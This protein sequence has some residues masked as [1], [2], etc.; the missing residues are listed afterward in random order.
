[1]SAARTYLVL[2]LA[3]IGMDFLLPKVTGPY[4]AVSLSAVGMVLFGILQHRPR[5]WRAWSVICLSQLSMACGDVIY[6]NVTSGYPGPADGFYLAA[7][8]LFVIGVLMLSAAGPRNVGFL[9]IDA[10][11]ITTACG[12][13]AWVLVFDGVA[14]TGSWIGR[15]VS[16]AY[17]LSDLTLL[18]LVARMLLAGGRRGPSFWFLLSSVIAL[19]VGDVVWVEPALD[20]TYNGG[21][22][23]MDA[24]WLGSYA[25]L[26]AAAL[27][28][29]MVA[30][31]RPCEA[32]DES[33]SMTRVL[34]VGAAIVFAPIAVVIADVSGRHV[35]LQAI[36]SAAAVLVLLVVVR[37]VLI[38]RDLE[39]LRRK[40]VASE[41]KFRM[42]F[43]RSPIGIS[44]GRD[45]I[46]SETNPA[47]QRMLGYS[48][49]EFAERHF[50]EITHPD[51]RDLE[52]QRKF[53][54]REL[55]AISLD[56][57]YV[58]KDGRVVDTRVRLALAL[59]DGL[60]MSLIEDVTEH[61]RLEAELHDAQK[62]E[63]VGKLA[64]GVAHDFNN[65]MTAVLGY[66]DLILARLPE[67][68]PNRGKLESI[69]EASVR[70][71]DL[72]RQLLAFGRKQMLRAS[73][74]DLRAIVVGL[75]PQLRELAGGR[76][77][78]VL[79]GAE[80]P[81]VVRGDPAQLEQVV[82]NLAENACEAMPDGGAL[83][84]EIGGD[85]SAAIL[86][87]SDTGAGIEPEVIGRIFEPFFTT[88]AVGA[89]P[90]LGLSTVYGIV[91]QSGGS[92]AVESMPGAGTSFTVR[93]PL[94]GAGLPV[95]EPVATLV[96]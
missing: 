15:A 6:D 47:L 84:I 23:W 82:L 71:S 64:G 11:L 48:A 35:N 93:L 34:A 90:G 32:E 13:A 8:V 55:E 41:R 80:E 12:I 44:V 22:S 33:L 2:A 25:L 94:V 46:L 39:R 29:S 77:E 24:A 85:D 21:V 88:K 27:H 38:V 89:G 54:A 95:D 53:D 59:E 4:D 51:D 68:D 86:V 87:V 28:P 70:A 74:V 42:V 40:A 75:E 61:R 37:F 78:L 65:L 5:A 73:D 9:N 18:G 83:T 49:E 56:K 57:R 17:P 31:V 43:E 72:T 63:A 69:R 91:G 3:G 92:V 66:S 16:F 1:M 20:G 10:L 45:G 79:Q 76:V 14:S 81:A 67:D 26:G 50:T 7:V 60:G 30:P 58:A 62:M 96:D 19:F 36:G 52:A